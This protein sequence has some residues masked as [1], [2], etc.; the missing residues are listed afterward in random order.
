MDTRRKITKNWFIEIFKFWKLLIFYWAVLI[1]GITVHFGSYGLARLW[2]QWQ[3]FVKWMPPLP[4]QS[5]IRSETMTAVGES[6]L[7]KWWTAYKLSNIVHYIRMYDRI[8]NKRNWLNGITG[9]PTKLHKLLCYNRM[10]IVTRSV[11]IRLYFIK[12]YA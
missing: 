9:R 11:V 12:H 8:C 1:L 4:N 2:V 5:R 7:M 3:Q 6:S 10:S